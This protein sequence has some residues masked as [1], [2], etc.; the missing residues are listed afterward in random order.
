M[1]IRQ[2]RLLITLVI[3][4]AIGVT[5]AIATPSASAVIKTLPNGHAVSYQPL[6]S[7]RATSGPSPFDLA[8]NNMDY[9]G[10][11]VMPSN[12]NYMLM[13]S[14]GGLGAYPGGFV[15]G[16]AQY[17]RDLAHDSGGNQN[18]DSV[19]PQYNDLTG[20]VASYDVTFGGVLVDTH[21]YPASQC[22]VNGA[23]TNC[24]TDAQVQQEIASFVTAHHLPTDLSHEY[25]LLTPPHVES[26]FGN[27]PATGYDG[28]SVGIDPFDYAA[29][30]AYHGNTTTSTMVFYA[31]M[32]FNAD[33]PYCQDGNYPNGSISDGEINGGLSHEH[34]ESVTDPIPNDAW[35]AGAGDVHGYEIGDVC[36]YDLGAPLGTAPNG[37]PYNQVI[38]GHRYWYQT[39]WSNYTH[40]CVQRL[41]L[42]HKLPKAKETV[43]AGRGTAMTFDASRSTF[44]GGLA[45]FSWQFNAVPN[46][47]TVEQTTPRTTYTFPARGAYS[48]GVA[49]F[50][51]DGL[52]SGTGGIVIPGKDGFQPAFTVSQ[53]RGTEVR[54]HALTTVSGKP[55]INYLWE[56][57]DGTSG[58]GATPTHTYRRPGA[59]TVKAVLFSGVGSAFPGD[60]A[61]PVYQQKIA[62]GEGSH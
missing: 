25:F 20:A 47:E 46:A 54:F 30:C 2:R 3:A 48:T 6:R 22:P 40:S 37:S 57:G 56:F 19:G 17:F 60:G 15:S 55:V 61:A 14:P 51:R 13:W 32:P 38:N 44:P 62:V 21:P 49:V 5:A 41:T 35:T 27:D 59:Y 24:L 1:R 11:P 28:C 10:G 36:A 33:S 58:S 29:Y 12:T 18:V 52:S 53:G 45:Q 31:N 7:A 23:V 42:P 43:T 39:E 16:I 9:N 4:G 50:S 26:C 8:F 34:M